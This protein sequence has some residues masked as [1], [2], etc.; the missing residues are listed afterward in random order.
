MKIFF[1][2]DWSYGECSLYLVGRELDGCVLHQSFGFAVNMA[3]IS[4]PLAAPLT[5][6]PQEVRDLTPH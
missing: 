1:P 3:F 4:G 6:D 5:L 2:A